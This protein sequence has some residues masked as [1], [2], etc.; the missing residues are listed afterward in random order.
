MAHGVYNM[1]YTYIRGVW[2]TLC[3]CIHPRFNEQRVYVC[4]VSV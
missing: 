3:A 2:V 4:D 1:I